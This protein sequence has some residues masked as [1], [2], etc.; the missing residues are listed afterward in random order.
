VRFR[1]NRN[2][3]KSVN[4][5]HA[6]R[7]HQAPDSRPDWTKRVISVLQYSRE[8]KEE[9]D[10]F[11]STAKNGLFQFYR[12]YMDYHADRF[13]D[14][15]LMVYDDAKLCAVFPAS[16]AEGVVCSHAGL[17]FGGVISTDRM[18][19]SLMISTLGR[20]AEHAREQQASRILYKA[21]P[22]PFAR[23]PAQED[24]YALF[25]LGGRLVRRDLSSVLRLDQRLPFSKGKHLGRVKAQKAGVTISHAAEL[26]TFMPILEEALA[27]HDVRPTHT[28]GELQLL[29]SRF[30]EY[31]RCVLAKAPGGQPLAGVVMYEYGKTAHVQY[32]ANSEEGRNAGALDLLVDHLVNEFYPPRAD[33]FSFGISTEQEGRYLNAGLCA[34]KEMF[35]ARSV[36][37]DHYELAL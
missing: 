26:S 17:T 12:G 23:L 4:K 18:T 8:R 3:A 30:P 9:W 2:H 35:G 37:H 29:Q 33:Y 10:A 11:I 6:R 34:Q 22:Y 20:I 19:A 32:M 16:R 25:S 5:R 15:S 13:A 14:G 28:L 7:L 27:R 36:V 1:Y 21:I 24:L 31:I